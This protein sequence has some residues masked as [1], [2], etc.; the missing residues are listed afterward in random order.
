M[1]RA[2][3]YS[4][5]TFDFTSVIMIERT[6]IEISTSGSLDVPFC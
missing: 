4:I 1:S 6:E 2:S 3:F 5:V